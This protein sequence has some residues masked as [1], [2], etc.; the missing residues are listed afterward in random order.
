MNSGATN[1]T[2]TDIA[3]ELSW[4]GKRYRTIRSTSIHSL[5]DISLAVRDGEFLSIGPVMKIG[6]GS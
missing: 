6:T 5:S 2:G 4:V 3:V 1:T